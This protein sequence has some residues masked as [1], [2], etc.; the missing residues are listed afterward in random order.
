MGFRGVVGKSGQDSIGFSGRAE[1]ASRLASFYETG[2]ADYKV[3]KAEP[4]YAK[5]LEKSKRVAGISK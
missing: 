3:T 2:E 1:L 4:Q 5:H